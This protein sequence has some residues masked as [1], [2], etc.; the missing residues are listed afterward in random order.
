MKSNQLIKSTESRTSKLNQSTASHQL[1]STQLNSTKL[2]S[3]KQSINQS[4]NSNQ[5]NSNQIKSNQSIKSTQSDNE[6]FA[7]PT[8]QKKSPPPTSL[9][10]LAWSYR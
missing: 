6:S 3:I 7:I 2:K 4:I 1:N 10:S 5:I 8:F 9:S